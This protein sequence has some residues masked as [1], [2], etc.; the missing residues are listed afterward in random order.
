MRDRGETKSQTLSE[1]Q[2][3]DGS[4]HGLVKGGPS[5]SSGHRSQDGLFTNVSDQRRRAGGAVMRTASCLGSSV[6]LE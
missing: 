3:P 4:C 5:N 6:C 2:E 1:L